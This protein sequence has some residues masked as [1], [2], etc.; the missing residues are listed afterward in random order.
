MFSTQF[1][2]L[3][4]A[5]LKENTTIAVLGTSVD[6]GVFLTMLDMLTDA[7]ETQHLK[8]SIVGKCWGRATVQVGGLKVLYQDLRTSKLDAAESQNGGMVCHDTHIAQK[9]GMF[10][11]ARRMIHQ[12]FSSSRQ[13]DWPRVVLL[14][15]GC[16]CQSFFKTGQDNADPINCVSKVAS[17]LSAV[18]PSWNGTV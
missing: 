3:E 8:E 11:D 18:P 16:P 7:R 17:L 15:S 10:L 6:R 13:Q 5:T 12:L 1:L 9:Q 2:R 4:A 14:N